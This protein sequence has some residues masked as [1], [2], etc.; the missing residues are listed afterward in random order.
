M[1]SYP[2]DTLDDAVAVPETRAERRDRATAD[3]RASI[4]TAARERLLAVGYA[5]LSTRTVADAAGVPLSQI[6][7]HF[8]SKQQLIL[9]VLEAENERLLARQ[10]SMYAGPEPLWRQ[11]ELACDYLDED[12]ES[13]YVRILQEMIAAGWSDAEVAAAVREYQLGWY[14]LLTQ[15]ARA[16]VEA[17][18]R[19]RAVRAEGGGGADGPAVHRRRVADPARHARVRPAGPGGPAQAR[20]RSS[21]R[22]RKGG[23]AAARERSPMTITPA[24][25]H[26]VTTADAAAI[27]ATIDDYYLGWYDADG[28]RMARALHPMLAK[29]GWRHGRDG[30]LSLDLDTFDT[31]VGAAAAGQGRQTDAAVRAYDISVDD[32]ARRHRGR[33][34]ARRPVRRLPPADPDERRLAHRERTLVP[35]LKPG[36][37]PL[38]VRSRDVMDRSGRE[39]TR[40]RYP[41]ETGYI[42]RDGVRVSWERYGDGS[43]TILLM[44][45]WSIFH[46]R[47]WKL[48]IPYLARHFRVLSFDGRGNG[49]SDRPTNIAAY[50][51]TEFVAD[52]VAVMDATGTDRAVAAGLSMGA[53]FAVRLAVEHPDRVIGLCLFGSTIPVNDR[54]PSDPDVGPD[55]DFDEVEADDE[56]WAQVQRPLL[57]PRLAG[58]CGLVLRRG[59]VH[60]AALDQ[61]G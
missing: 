23:S 55:A 28:D 10:R 24:T 57:A 36:G 56:G 17:P 4:L 25:V 29:R 52:A 22:S 54:K 8:G 50:A 49:R 30:A 61:G 21:G 16:R 14:R 46:S 20:R 9:D 26:P 40:A 45:T 53:G 43:P 37:R 19:P 42:V 47:H 6:H 59:R 44:P 51:D 5:N 60:G 31:M 3:T 2:R 7:Y 27:R 38:A 48:Q 11:W 13:G 18:G 34:R 15:V 1:G 35:G 12:I 58:L 39:Q 41:D 33:D 32:V